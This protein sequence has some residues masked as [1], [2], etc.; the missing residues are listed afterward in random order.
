MTQ[1]LN[2]WPLERAELE[3]VRRHIAVPC[4]NPRTSLAN[5]IPATIASDTF[6]LDLT[7][8][9]S[10]R[11]ADLTS[12]SYRYCDGGL[13]PAEARSKRRLDHSLS[14]DR[15]DWLTENPA[16]R[17]IIAASR[18]FLQSTG[19]EKDGGRSIRFDLIRADSR[20]NAPIEQLEN[21]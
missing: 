13:M 9:G 10:D 4:N 1:L 14:H 21:S 7:A 5:W 18:R 16:E 17:L 3:T 19:D 11:P 2:Y 12:P 6:R 8:R 20:V 15:A